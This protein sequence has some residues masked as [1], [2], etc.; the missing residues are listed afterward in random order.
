[1]TCTTCGEQKT[2]QVG[3]NWWLNDNTR[4]MFNYGQSAIAGGFL[5]GNNVNDGADIKGF[6]TRLQIDW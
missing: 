1:V 5:A 3:V 6:G 4:I 2:W